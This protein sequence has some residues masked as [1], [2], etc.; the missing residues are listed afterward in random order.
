MF[1]TRLNLFKIKTS[2]GQKS[3]VPILPECPFAVF[4][5]KT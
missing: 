4:K 5:I 1:N 3:E 2:I